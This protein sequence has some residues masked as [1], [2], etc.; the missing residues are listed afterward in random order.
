[1]K[2]K[3]AARHD[4][5]FEYPL[6]PWPSPIEASGIRGIAKIMQ[7]NGLSFDYSIVIDIQS[8]DIYDRGENILED[9]F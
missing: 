2:S 8:K 3:L 4:S 1:L 9:L 6:D 7:P 5:I